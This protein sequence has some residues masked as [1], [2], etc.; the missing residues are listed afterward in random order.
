MDRGVVMEPMQGKL[1]TSQFDLGYT[2]LFCLPEVISV[3][4]S[5]VTVLLGSPWSSI[6]Q[7]ESH[8]LFDWENTIALHTMHWN[9][10]SSRGEGEV[11]WVFSSC[12]RNLGCILEIKQ[13]CPF[14]TG[15]CSVKSEHLSRYDGLLRNIN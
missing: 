2:E 14:E 15:V 7:I 4:I 1:A 13:R 6:K 11:S 3:F 9:Q 8:Y 10:A 5:V 12:C